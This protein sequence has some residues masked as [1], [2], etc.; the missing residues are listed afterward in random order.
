M[1][2]V[3]WAKAQEVA[4]GKVPVKVRVVAAAWEVMLPVPWV[5]VFAQSAMRRLRMIAGCLAIHLSVP[6][7]K[8]G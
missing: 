1:E 3:Q 5:N 7:A 8:L 2:Q 6:S 4:L